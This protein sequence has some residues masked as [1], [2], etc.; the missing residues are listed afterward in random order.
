VTEAQEHEL[1]Q[2]KNIPAFK[3]IVDQYQGILHSTKDYLPSEGYELLEY[4]IYK[5]LYQVGVQ[6]LE[7]LYILYN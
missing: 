1:E 2:L 7:D 6:T 5:M 3:A 4:S